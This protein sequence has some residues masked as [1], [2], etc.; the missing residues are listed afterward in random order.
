M[1]LDP[2][3]PLIDSLKKI[4]GFENFGFFRG[5]STENL[6]FCQILNFKTRKL[7]F[8]VFAIYFFNLGAIKPIFS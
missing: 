6:Y 2:P 3:L 1:T 5:L 8:H 7:G 4:F